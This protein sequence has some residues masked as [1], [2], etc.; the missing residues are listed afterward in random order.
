[1]NHRICFFED[2]QWRQF[3]PLTHLR[4][5][6]CLRAGIFPLFRRVE[7]F[8]DQPEISLCG[9]GSLAPVIS[10]EYR[11]YPVN[12]IKRREGQTVLFLNGRLRDYGNLSE[13]IGKSQLVTKITNQQ[14]VLV[15]LSF[16]DAAV[17]GLPRVA[18]Q[19]QYV[20]YFQKNAG[21][22]GEM[23][24]NA[25]LY[26][27]CWDLVADIDKEITHDFAHLKRT[28]AKSERVKV[29]DGVFALNAD[30]IHLGSGVEILPGSF[31]DA[32]HGSVFVGDNTRVESQVAIYGPCYIGPNSV[33]VAGKISGCSIGHTCRV[34]GEVEE[35]VFQSYVNKYHAGFIGHSY[36]GSWVNFGAMTTNSDLKNNYSTIQV[37]VGGQLIDTGSIKVGSFIGDHTKFGIG[38]LL[39]TGINVGMCCNIYGGTLI[40]DR[41]VPSFRW[42]HSAGYEIYRFEKAI[43]TMRRTA[44]RRNVEL[45]SAEET[46]LQDVY[47]GKVADLGT[48]EL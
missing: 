11:D 6:Y 4:P 46:L 14:G 26:E 1:M 34:G 30:Q 31:I 33:V 9:R 15:G 39:N 45:T 29:H 10:A 24:T 47:D 27:W 41:E 7:R 17:E 48:L 19:E 36:V 28:L 8:F 16:P 2:R 42:G 12:I 32:S 5:V 38:T 13:L 25:T 40:T 43:K 23:E 44:E 37:S 20:E 35:S 18:T 21:D 22:A 3:L